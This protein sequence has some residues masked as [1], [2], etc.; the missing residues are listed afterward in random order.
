MKRIVFLMIVA[1]VAAAVAGF[2]GVRIWTRRWRGRPDLRNQDSAWI[3]R[4]EIGLRGS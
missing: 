3:P 2:H 4:L 1:A